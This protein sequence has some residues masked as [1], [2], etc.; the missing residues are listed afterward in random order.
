M[1]SVNRSVAGI[2]VHKKM[3][4]VVIRRQSGGQVQYEKR[5]FGTTRAEIQHLEAW[6]W[7]RADG[8]RISATRSGWRTGGARDIWKTVSFPWVG[9]CPGSQESAGG[10][11]PPPII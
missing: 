6:L 1:E 7:R 5:G 4:A 10:R 11:S 9:V 3:L 2:D 8:S